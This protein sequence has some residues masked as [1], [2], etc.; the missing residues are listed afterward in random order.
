MDQLTETE[1]REQVERLKGE[2]FSANVEVENLRKQREDLA[3]E[4]ESWKSADSKVVTS[5]QRYSEQLKAEKKDLE[6]QL[7]RL[8]AEKQGFADLKAA[9][10]RSLKDAHLRSIALLTIDNA[11]LRLR[12]DHCLKERDDLAAQLEKFKAAAESK[13]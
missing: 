1:L 7:E 3:Q 6:R 4:V 8:R 11:G 2:L 13:V 9:V 12:Y 10:S 5:L